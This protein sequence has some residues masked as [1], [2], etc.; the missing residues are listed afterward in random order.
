MINQNVFQPQCLIIDGY[1]FNDES[2]PAMEELKQLMETL[3]F[4]VD[5]L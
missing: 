1:E 5:C 2:R 4:Y 3:Y